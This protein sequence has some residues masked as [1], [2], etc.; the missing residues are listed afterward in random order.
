MFDE[1]VPAVNW[2]F[3][4]LS[5]FS[6]WLWTSTSWVGVALIG[7]LLFRKVVDIFRKLIH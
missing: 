6:S 5:K 2:I 4:E 7:L 3:S 1:L